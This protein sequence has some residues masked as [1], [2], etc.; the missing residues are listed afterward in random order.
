[1]LVGGVHLVSILPRPRIR[2]STY[3]Y[4]DFNFW[5]KNY[6]GKEIDECPLLIRLF[7]CSWCFKNIGSALPYQG[8]IVA[9]HGHIP[10]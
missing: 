10:Q 5:R 7:L 9:G 1:M 8:S 4:I 3:S 2:G 6:F